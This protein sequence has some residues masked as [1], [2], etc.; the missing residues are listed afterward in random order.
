MIKKNYRNLITVLENGFKKSIKGGIFMFTCIYCGRKYYVGEAEWIGED[1]AICKS[2]YQKT[3]KE[4]NDLKEE[5]G[6]LYCDRCKC[7]FEFVSAD[8]LIMTFKAPN[9]IF[10]KGGGPIRFKLYECPICGE[11]KFFRKK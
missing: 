3:N 2:C 5:L 9:L 4:K 6:S 10:N 1:T 11:L 7:P 8:N